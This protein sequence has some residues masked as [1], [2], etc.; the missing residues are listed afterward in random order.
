MPLTR[1]TALITGAG[2]LATSAARADAAAETRAEAWLAAWD[3]HGLHRTATPGDEAGADWLAREA[4][5]I[6]ASPGFETFPLERIDTDAA[7]VEIEGVR[8][9]GEKL[10]DSPDTPDGRVMALASFGPEG[11]GLVNVLE[12]SPLA[13]Y[14]PE[15]VRLRRQSPNRAWVIITRGGAPGLALLNA[16][17]F[18][19]PYGPPALQVSSSDGERV[20][21][22][23]RRG[24]ALRVVLRSRRMPVLARNVVLTVK[25]SDPARPPVVVMTP[26]SSWF[27]SASERGGGLVCWLECLRA[28]RAAPPA[29]DVIFTANSGHELGHIG[30]DAFMASRPG[31]ERRAV[32][33]HFG[34]NIGA[35]GGK[36][37]LQSA[38]DA[39]RGLTADALRESGQPADSVAVK[40]VVPNGE[41]RDIHRAGGRYVT[42]VGSN[43]LFHL[44]QDRYPDAVD[45]PAIARI[46]AAMAQ[47]AVATTR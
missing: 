17:S 35:A 3:G 23:A 37:G 8:I 9:P 27:Q 16:E 45:V 26:R 32:W 11:G 29:C 15:F 20:M 36:L 2:L 14:S 12:F 42:L 1:R 6:G 4:A 24:A 33:L 40:T 44:P 18:R 46:A 31:L 39:L 13:V 25:G 21:E 7:F 10:L 22:A 34:A 19:A 43:R 5:G 47:V 30:L 28:L 41:S 38:D